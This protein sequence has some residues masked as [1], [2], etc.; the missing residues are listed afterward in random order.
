M[1]ESFMTNE[2][3]TIV[4]GGVPPSIDSDDW[5]GLVGALLS[6]HAEQLKTKKDGVVSFKFS[7]DAISIRRHEDGSCVVEVAIQSRPTHFAISEEQAKHLAGL[8]LG[9]EVA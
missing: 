9:K 2:P 6:K 7:N 8:L 1:G 5:L 3:K 4:F